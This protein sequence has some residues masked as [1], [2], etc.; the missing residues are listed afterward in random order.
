MFGFKSEFVLK[1]I[2]LDVNKKS[3]T[4]ILGPNGS[5]K[6]SLMNIITGLVEFEGQVKI[7]GHDITKESYLT[8][9]MTGICPQE[10]VYFKYLSIREHLKLVSDL[11]QTLRESDS[12]Y[13]GGH[14]IRLLN[15]ESELNKEA[16]KLSGGTLRRLVLAVALIGPND[17]LLLDEPTAALDP[18]IRRKVWD[19]ILDSRNSKT[20]LITSHHLEEANLLSDQICIISKGNNEELVYELNFEDSHRFSEMFDDLYANES[21]LAINDISLGMTTLEGSYAK[22]VSKN[23]QMMF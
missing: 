23:K 18:I 21:Y 14:L 16:F 1:D 13:N 10:N 2:D 6:T 7:G 20:V 12:G 22:I 5:G 15:L 8:R 4:V 11:K 3:I 17:V 9:N 19:L